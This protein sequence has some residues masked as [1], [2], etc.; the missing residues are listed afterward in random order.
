LEKP[1]VSRSCFEAM[2]RKVHLFY[3]MNAIFIIVIKSNST[4][5]GRSNGAN[6]VLEAVVSG[7]KVNNSVLFA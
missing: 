4:S 1:A 7:A 5:N 6:G 2:L 3:T